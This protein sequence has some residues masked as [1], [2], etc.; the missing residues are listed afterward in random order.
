MTAD[1][2]HSKGGGIDFGGNGKRDETARIAGD[3]LLIARFEFPGIPFA[4]AC[5]PRFLEAED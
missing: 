4:E 1:D 5:E 2:A 3:V